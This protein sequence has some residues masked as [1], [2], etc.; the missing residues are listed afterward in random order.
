MAKSGDGTTNPFGDGRG[1]AGNGK[2]TPANLIVNPRGGGG[3]GVT[4]RVLTATNSNDEQ[5]SG[6][7][8][9]MN[10]D[11]VVSDGVEPT[12]DPPQAEDI[13]TRAI[14][15]NANKPFKLVEG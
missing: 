12:I 13:G 3:N 9:T 14:G 11:S 4:P 8:P 2:V 5:A 1:G 7:D 10:A 6:G 15:Q